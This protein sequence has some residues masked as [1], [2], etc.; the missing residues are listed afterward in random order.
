MNQ[1]K[2]NN[3]NKKLDKLNNENNTLC[4]ILLNSEINI[5]LLK[6]F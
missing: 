4:K 3:I 6:I 2:V 1:L 5:I